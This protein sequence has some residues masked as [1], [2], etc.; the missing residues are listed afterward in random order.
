MTSTIDWDTGRE[1][2]TKTVL[3]TVGFDYDFTG[4]IFINDK[5]YLIKKD[6]GDCLFC[7][8]YTIS[9]KGHRVYKRLVKKSEIDN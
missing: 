8:R 7:I 5:V 9:S 1:Y 4:S 2:K 3:G 6:T